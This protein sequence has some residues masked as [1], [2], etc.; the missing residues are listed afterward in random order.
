M[1]RRYDARPG[2]VPERPKGTGC[3]PVGSAF[4]GSNPL[5]PIFPTL[6][7]LFKPCLGWILGG[8]RPSG[9]RTLAQAAVLS[10]SKTQKSEGIEPW[11]WRIRQPSVVSTAKRVSRIGAR[12]SPLPSET[13]T[14]PKDAKPRVPAL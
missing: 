6:G 4:R 9:D 13:M 2:G 3:K 7:V 8:D 14:S 10:L 12:R 11:N 1:Y 5:S